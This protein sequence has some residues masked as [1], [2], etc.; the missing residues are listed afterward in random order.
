MQPS[1]FLISPPP[2]KKFETSLKYAITG[3]DAIS[4]KI[5]YL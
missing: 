5:P 1:P 3:K 4:N 2:L